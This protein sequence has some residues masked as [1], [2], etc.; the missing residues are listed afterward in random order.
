VGVKQWCLLSLLLF[1]LFASDV[2]MTAEGVQGAV[3]GSGYVRV[4]NMLCAD[5]LTL[6]ANAPGALQTMFN[7][8]LIV[9]RLA[10]AVHFN[11]KA[12]AKVPLFNV[13][14]DALKCS[15]AFRY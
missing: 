8:L 2:G 10:E 11:S 5:S 4:T 12:G 13:G 9:F 6:L 7:C 1:S 14:G 15:E 3:T